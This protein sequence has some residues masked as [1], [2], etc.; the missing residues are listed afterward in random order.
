MVACRHL[1][2]TCIFCVQDVRYEVF[3]TMLFSSKDAPLAFGSCDLGRLGVPTQT[4]QDPGK[5]VI[6]LGL[7]TLA[8]TLCALRCGLTM[9]PA[10]VLQSAEQLR[11]EDG[12]DADQATQTGSLEKVKV[13]GW[14]T[15]LS[16]IFGTLVHDRNWLPRRSF[17][18]TVARLKSAFQTGHSQAERLR[19]VECGKFETNEWMEPLLWESPM[20][21]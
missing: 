14:P 13:C 21:P 10:R 20:L 18:L 11:V 9:L 16:R 2:A 7:A 17:R 15:K 1:V 8:G 6:L 3:R 5:K 4:S 19:W 12:T